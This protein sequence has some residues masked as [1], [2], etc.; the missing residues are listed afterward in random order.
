MTGKWLFRLENSKGEKDAIT[1]CL[2]WFKN[3]PD[4]DSYSDSL[5]VCPC[6]YRQ[7][8]LD[9]RF[10]WVASQTPD[11]YCVYTRFPSSNR[12]GRKCCYQ[13]FGAI[14]IGYPGGGHIDRYHQLTASLNLYHDIFDVRGFKQCCLLSNQC[15]LFYQKRPS[16]GC[17]NYKPPVWSKC[18]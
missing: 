4:P 6:T 3:Q 17:E 12:R 10:Q 16:E 15:K 18:F 7:A 2:R 14:I 8:R 11:S 13:A 5:E 1:K 9:E